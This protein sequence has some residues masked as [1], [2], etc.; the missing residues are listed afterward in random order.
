MNCVFA[1][2]TVFKKI[3]AAL[4]K[5]LSLVNFHF[6]EEGLK[7]NA[8]NDSHTDMR[9]FVL[10]STFFVSYIC[11]KPLVLGINVTVLNTFVKTAGSKDTITWQYS[12]EAVEK[13]LI[14]TVQDA[15][16]NKTC[17][18]FFIK[19]IDFEED[20]LSLPDTIDWDCHFRVGTALLRQW[21]SKAK[22][23]DGNIGISITKGKEISINVKS[24]SM[25]NIQINQ[26]IPSVM[27]QMVKSSPD[28][29]TQEKRISSK[30]AECLDVLIQCSPG[31]DIQFENN[32]PMSCTS[33]LDKD[34]KS[35]VRLW[36]APLIIE[37][38]DD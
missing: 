20:A 34:K 27:A 28:F 16:E 14:M 17:T 32:M 24:D 21:I 2:P 18:K 31:V 19:L 25:G 13:N 22:L 4:S 6:N 1:D 12:D 7:I 30:E 9:E 23:I 3:I 5:D 38:E 8:M 10:D 29:I 26:P 36:I 11:D 33:Y 35:Y 37:E 15:S